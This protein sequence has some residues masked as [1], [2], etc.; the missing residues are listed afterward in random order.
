MVR[1]ISQ[2][3][4]FKA[5]V[6]GYRAAMRKRVREVE[7]IPEVVRVP[8][9]RRIEVKPKV[10]VPE[11]RRIELE[12]VE[13]PPFVL[14]AVKEAVKIPEVERERISMVYPLIPRKP[15]PKDLVFAYA[16]IFWNS[17][18]NRYIYQVVEP[19]L[20][21]RLAD[22]LKKVKSLLEQK[23][24]VDLSKLTKTEAKEYLRK[25]MEE[26]IRYYG[27]KLHP[28]ER[29]I[30]HYY[31]ERDFIG[32][33]KI[34]PLMNDEQIE[35]VSCDGLGAPI[36]VF[37]RNPVLGSVVTNLVYKDVDE[38]DSFIIKLSQLCG[39]S[40]SVAAPILSGTLP[41]GSRVHATLATD[42]ARKG[43]NYTIRKFTEFPLTPVH[44]LTYG[45]LDIKT[46]AFLWLCV[47]YGMSIFVS[48]GTATGKTSLLNV[49][50]MFIRP[51]KKIVSIEDS[52]TGDCRV[53]IKKNGSYE[54]R[55]VS[56]LFEKEKTELVIDEFGR[57]T[58]KPKNLFTLS[59][60][61]SNKIVFSPISK[62][63]RHKVR[64][65]L[66]KITTKSGRII[67]V[68]EDHSVFTLDENGKI[69]PI[70]ASE[71]TENQFLATPRIW[72]TPS[73]SINSI[74]LLNYLSKLNEFYVNGEPVERVLGKLKK[75]YIEKIGK[76]KYR[77]WYKNKIIHC[78][79]LNELISKIKLRKRDIKKI[80]IKP[81]HPSKH[82]LPVTLTLDKNFLTF[83]GLWLSEGSYDKN[84]IIIT[85][86]D[87]ECRLIIR[88]A[89]KRF[90]IIPKRHSDGISMM[91]NSSCLKAIMT[92][93][94]GLKGNAYTKKIPAW[95]FTLS[96]RQIGY[97]LRGYFSGDGHVTK[98]EIEVSSCS[99][100]LIKDLQTLLLFFGIISRTSW[101][102]ERD[103]TYKLR[104]SGVNN[105]WI[106][107]NKIDF[108]QKEKKEQTFLL[109][110]RKPHEISDV[111]PLPKHFYRPLKYTFVDE[112][113]ITR[114]Y[115]GWKNW[116]RRYTAQDSNIM[117]NTIQK[118]VSKTLFNGNP[119]LPNLAF[120]DIFWDKIKSIKKLPLKEKFVYDISIPKFE[121]FVCNNFIV[122][123]TAELRLPHP[124]WVPQVA[125]VPI[126]VEKGE[127]DLF[128]LLKE[129]LRQRP[130][131]IVV[132]E[133]RGPEAF[134][135]FQQIATGHPSL[136]TIHAEDMTKLIDRLITPPISLPPLLLENLNLIVFLLQ[137]RHRDRQVRRAG[138]ILEIVGFDREKN[139]PITNL[140]FKWNPVTD[141]FDVKGRSILIRKM[142]EARGIKEEEVVEEVQR[143]MLVLGWM[144]EKNL[145]DYRDVF[146]IISTYYTQPEKIISL[147]KG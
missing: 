95:V 70:K 91:I 67:K 120:S 81:C 72:P 25:R 51:E 38:L 44:L 43:S 123:N 49:L 139:I 79:V 74:N 78:R 22:M 69:S 116:H 53:F 46:L 27:F 35:D 15:A 14:P 126:A 132:G 140:L 93:V 144:L 40:V 124:H 94:L 20:V 104:I 73:K 32:L 8:E 3:A 107:K 113:G 55:K 117:R 80:K 127:V 28:I 137:T 102:K 2:R 122:H 108:L 42:I 56:N 68:T 96:K 77:Y 18:E 131:Y 60:S 89:S 23:L 63:I 75:K 115:S 86:S 133:V 84:S 101:R 41:D 64:K 19:E 118:L 85:N 71:L 12:G 134:V 87:R 128:A 135:L 62:L 130:D 37:H 31:A 17:T 143:R 13:I 110:S 7:I 119:M 76:S 92:R 111:I 136:A 36:F 5:F 48:G 54:Y 9:I 100:E 11:I 10:R 138:E 29:E 24:D 34:E 90:N 114:T 33:G 66:Y 47:D 98:N 103:N 57:E 147:V 125:R 83:V 88:K 65:N 58:Y 106:F 16:K 129:S 97:L 82:A 112:I 1:K 26:V 4:V 145:L 6:K 45:T 99:K 52:V 142:A 105:V 21:P 121:N 61:D 50:S 109:S 146:K 39:K 141:A 30:L 59:L